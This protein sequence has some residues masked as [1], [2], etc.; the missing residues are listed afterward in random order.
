MKDTVVAEII[1]ALDEPGEQRALG[2]QVRNWDQK[3]WDENRL[4]IVKRGNIA[5]VRNI[6]RKYI[7][8]N[9]SAA[10]KFCACGFVL[11]YVFIDR[12]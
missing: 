2:R 4:A 6:Y 11:K 3:L 10:F 7:L 5:K 9:A 1:M 12:S 8:I